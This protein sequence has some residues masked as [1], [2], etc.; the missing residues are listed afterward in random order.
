VSKIINEPLSLERF[1]VALLK[2]GSTLATEIRPGPPPCFDGIN[3]G[4]AFLEQSPPH[5]GERH[6]DGDELVYLMSGNISVFLEEEP[7]RTIHVEPGQC[8]IIPKGVWHR[9]LVH[10]PSRL[11]Y[12]TPGPG[13]EARPR[14]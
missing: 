6:T 3:V 10:G 5:N 1:V 12:I 8:F 11:M 2:D 7:P 4:V 14:F 13:N 9:L